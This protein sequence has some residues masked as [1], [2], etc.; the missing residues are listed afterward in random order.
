MSEHNAVGGVYHSRIEAQAAI[1]ELQRSGFGMRKSKSH[2][3]S[4]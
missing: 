2:R 4:S 3:P 1:K